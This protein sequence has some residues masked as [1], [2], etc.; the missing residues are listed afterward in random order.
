MH[1]DTWGILHLYLLK[2][3]KILKYDFIFLLQQLPD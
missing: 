1:E 2:H 3:T